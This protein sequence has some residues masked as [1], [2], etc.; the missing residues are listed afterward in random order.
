MFG[1]KGGYSWGYKQLPPTPYFKNVGSID[2]DEEDDE[3]VEFDSI[4]DVANAVGI[5]EKTL[6]WHYRSK[7][8]AL[9]TFSNINFYRNQLNTFPSPHNKSDQFGISATFVDGFY[10]RTK[11]KT[12]EQNGQKKRITTGSATNKNEAKAIAEADMSI[13]NILMIKV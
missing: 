1:E 10:D 5:T 8:E 9:I 2:T 11:T 4:L 3:I 12:I 7:H 6:R 13:I